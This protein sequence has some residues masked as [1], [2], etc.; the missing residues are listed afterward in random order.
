MDTSSFKVGQE[1]KLNWD[2][3][4]PDLPKGTVVRIIQVI[5]NGIVRIQSGNKTVTI[6][7]DLLIE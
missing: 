5:E 6:T 2:I 1:V 4:G 3:P 7:D